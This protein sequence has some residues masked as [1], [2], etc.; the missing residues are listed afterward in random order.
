MLVQVVA[1]LLE[2]ER[3][4][5]RILREKQEANALLREVAQRLREQGG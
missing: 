3:K 4:L 2:L 1:L 5:D